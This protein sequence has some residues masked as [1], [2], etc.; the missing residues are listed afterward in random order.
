VSGR[1]SFDVTLDGHESSEEPSLH[2]DRHVAAHRRA[3]QRARRPEGHAHR[4]DRHCTHRPGAV[5]GQPCSTGVA[6][7]R[8]RSDVGV[9]RRG[10][11]RAGD[12]SVG[13]AAPCQQDE[14]AHDP[15]KGKAE[16]TARMPCP[17]GQEFVRAAGGVV[18]PVNPHAP[19]LGHRRCRHD[20]AVPPSAHRL[21]GRPHFPAAANGCDRIRR[22]PRRRQEPVTEAEHRRAQVSARCARAR[23]RDERSP[24]PNTLVMSAWVA[25]TT[26][27]ARWRAARSELVSPPVASAVA[28]AESSFLKVGRV[29][30]RPST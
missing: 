12:H 24:P 26:S 11:A 2:T 29:S 22:S 28:R 21:T 6:R 7:R 18:D 23:H 9:S 17:P 8:A 27:W 15:R 25:E 3:S 20:L 16:P 5:G 10:G 19:R 14:R 1:P 30:D 4:C 13:A